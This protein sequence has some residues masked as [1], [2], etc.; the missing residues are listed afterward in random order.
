LLHLISSNI[1]IHGTI[2]NGLENVKTDYIYYSKTARN[3]LDLVQA[4]PA[5]QYK[6]L[7]L[8]TRTDNQQLYLL[9][10]AWAFL[11][12]RIRGVT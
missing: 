4:V 2:S 10:N 3:V 6:E 5:S 1:S 8:G 11:H 9:Q 7:H 12:V